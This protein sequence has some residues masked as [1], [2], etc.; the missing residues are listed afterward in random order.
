[1]LAFVTSLLIAD[2]CMAS[3]GCSGGSGSGCQQEIPCEGQG[4]HQD[5]ATAR[6]GGLLVGAACSFGGR[7][8]FSGL[9]GR[10]GEAS[11]A[12]DCSTSFAH[13]GPCG[14][15]P[16]LDTRSGGRQRGKGYGGS[17]AQQVA[18][19]A[20]VAQPSEAEVLTEQSRLASTG[21]L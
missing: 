19:S 2:A 16:G 18:D 4:A 12:A 9:V 17:G 7:G 3:S 5:A 11:S 15:G 20:I 8:S 21:V 10:Q 1:M 14:F 6:G 13:E